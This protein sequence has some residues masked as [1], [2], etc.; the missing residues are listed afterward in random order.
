MRFRI[1]E[2]YTTINSSTN[3]IYLYNVVHKIYKTF[4]LM[5]LVKPK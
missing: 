1:D 4:M 5:I 2:N 3:F